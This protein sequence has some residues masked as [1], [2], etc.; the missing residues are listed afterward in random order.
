MRVVVPLPADR[1]VGE[2][3]AAAAASS[4]RLLGG[5]DPIHQ[6]EVQVASGLRGVYDPYGQPLSPA[7]IPGPDE[8]SIAIGDPGHGN[9]AADHRRSASSRPKPLR[10]CGSPE[11]ID[12]AARHRIQ[13]QRIFNFSYNNSNKRKG[14]IKGFQP[15][16]APISSVNSTFLVSGISSH[17]SQLDFLCFQE[18]WSTRLT[19]RL[20]RELHQLYPYIIYDVGAYNYDINF[21]ALNSGLMFA[22]KY[23]IVDVHFEPFTD[24]M[25][26][27]V[28][29]SKGLLMVKV[30]E[31]RLLK[32]L[33]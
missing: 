24:D 25:T 21:Y 23:S 17:F 19:K 4:L 13:Y 1:R 2:N 8:Q 18:C 6:D 31:G 16:P 26:N 33:W 10:G 12:P 32:R 28:F 15:R 27:G 20:V 11:T 3:A 9:R 14:K 30:S 22:S 5:V 29:D 7:R